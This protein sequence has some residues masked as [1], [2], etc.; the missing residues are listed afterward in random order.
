MEGGDVTQPIAEVAFAALLGG[1]LGLPFRALHRPPLGALIALGVGMGIARL[2]HAPWAWSALAALSG[3]A[4]ALLAPG[5]GWWRRGEGSFASGTAGGFS[6][7]AT[8]PGRIAR[9]RPSALLDPAD[10]LRIEGAVLEIARKLHREGTTAELFQRVMEPT[11]NGIKKYRRTNGYWMNVVSGSRFRPE[12][13]DWARSFVAD[14]AN[15][16]VEEI[17]A[18]AKQYLD[19]AQAVVVVLEPEGE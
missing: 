10:R 8:A 6:R 7:G 16:T 9:I 18:Y 17:N 13:I 15:M 11:R 19:P 5:L 12:Q 3:A 4:L 1:L 2:L 14:Y